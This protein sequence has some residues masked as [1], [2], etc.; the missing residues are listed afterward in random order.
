MNLGKK[1]KQL[2]E[3]KVRSNDSSLINEALN[4]PLIDFGKDL[5]KRL[6]KFNFITKIFTDKEG[7]PMPVKQKVG[8]SPEPKRAAISY[9]KD[10]NYEHI[11]VVVHK[12]SLRD[13]EK[14]VKYFNVPE[15]E[16]GPEK[17]LGWIIKN[18][19][20]TN[21]GDI[22]RSRVDAQA[23]IASVRYF[24]ASE[25]AASSISKDKGSGGSVF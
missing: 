11:E 21:P 15:G 4:K 25:S 14:V 13:L 19:K 24:T 9:I 6:E 3:G 16:Y 22:V 18:V 2:F 20:V 7:V 5:Q 23:K 12:K 17:E 1:Y 10:G 8:E